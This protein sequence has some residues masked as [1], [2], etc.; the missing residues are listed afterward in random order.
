[1]PCERA[2]K[3][4]SACVEQIFFLVQAQSLSRGAALEIYLLAVWFLF[5]LLFFLCFS[6]PL[7]GTGH[8]MV[9]NAL[10]CLGS[11]TIGFLIA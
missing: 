2:I 5:V 6:L 11:D 9:A 8:G 7:P 3:S 4:D 1:M 10:V